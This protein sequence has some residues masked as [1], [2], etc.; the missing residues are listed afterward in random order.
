MANLWFRGQ[1]IYITY[2]RDGKQVH[3]ATHL[4]NNKENILIAKQMILDIEKGNQSPIPQHKNI[5]L[6]DGL[7]LF[8]QQKLISDNN[9]GLYLATVSIFC[10][11]NGNIPISTVN[12]THYKRFVETLRSTFYQRY[13]EQ[14]THYSDYTINSRL[15]YLKALFNFFIKK[16]FYQSE[17]PFL[18]LKVHKKYIRTVAQNDVELILNN[19]DDN[20]RYYISFLLESGFRKQEA[21][22]IKWSDIDYTNNIIRVITRKDQ[23]RPDYFPL[24]P[25]ISVLLSHIPKQ[26]ELI[27]WNCN[28]ALKVMQK[29]CRKLGLQ[30]YT[31]HDLRRTFATNYSSKLSTVELMTVMRHKN[32]NTTL[33][34][35]IN[36]NIQ[37]IANKMS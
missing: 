12:S 3:L 27:F 37:N 14:K 11:I 30:L 33:Q 29:V 20:I 17:N 32:I 16:G 6:T 21:L 24:L 15:R 2:S 7:Q 5:S 13:N 1:S 22:S 19:L 10:K 26:K 4:K 18:L 8:F 35:Y 34:Y 23:N 9:K 36:H 31:L 28:N 25:N